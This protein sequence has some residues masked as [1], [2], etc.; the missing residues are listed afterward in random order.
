MS[1]P[2]YINVPGISDQEAALFEAWQDRLHEIH[3]EEQRKLDF[4]ADALPVLIGLIPKFFEHLSR[5][6]QAELAMKLMDVLRD[7][8]RLSNGK[9][10]GTA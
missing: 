4:L 7:A 1:E 3:I 9:P 6:E 10:E 5:R 2:S 8:N